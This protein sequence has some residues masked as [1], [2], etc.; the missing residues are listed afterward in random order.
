MSREMDSNS[1]PTA[2]WTDK[3]A[4]YYLRIAATGIVPAGWYLTSLPPVE[5]RAAATGKLE[6]EIVSHCWNYAHFLTYQ[7]SSLVNFPPTKMNVTMTVFYT[8]EDVRTK[9]LLEY[10][11]AME[12]PGV[13]WNWR[14]LP[15]EQLFRRSIGRN[16]RA[17]ETEAH[18]I[19]FTDC[20][21]LFRE[22]CLDTLAEELQGRRDALVYP[23]QER[24]TPMLVESDPML[25]VDEKPEVIDIAADRFMVNERGRATGPLQIVH[26]DVARACGYCEQLKLYQKPSAT[27]CKHWE[28]KAFRW[29]LRT[30]GVPLDV[31]GVYRIRHVFKGRYTGHPISNKTRSAIRRTK[32]WFKERGRKKQLGR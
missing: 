32:A 8:E 20:D 12:V 4:G 5:D 3:P 16:R 27:Y 25:S 2:G 29:L 22:N 10:F 30:E 17:R 19:W 28:D 6:L 1:V 26:G 7:L 15:R 23:R 14:R 31:P 11:G 21:L 9:R 24:V 13:A 18:W